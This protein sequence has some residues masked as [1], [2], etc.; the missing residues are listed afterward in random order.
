MKIQK[1]CEHCG[2]TFCR[3]PSELIVRKGIKT[4]GRFC[5]RN[6]MQE[7]RKNGD[8][9]IC[10]SCGKPFYR[11][12]GEQDI[13]ERNNQFCSKGCY[14]KY[15]LQNMKDTTYPKDGGEHLHRIIA[16]QYLGRELL[17]K[18]IIHHID[19]N[20]HNYDIENLALFSSQAT[21]AKA[22]FSKDFDIEPYKITN[23]KR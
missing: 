11:R 12:F 8:D 4:A 5:S 3:Y 7:S 6:C 10:V 18:E 16:E 23:V 21:H 17:P 19:E 13:G 14:S 2:K 15:R 9:V 20:K 22:H 1:I